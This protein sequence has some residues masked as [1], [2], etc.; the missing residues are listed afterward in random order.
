M[1][2][3]GDGKGQ[4]VLAHAAALARRH[5]AHVTV[6]HCRARAGDMM[7]YGVPVPALVRRQIE[8]SAASLADEEERALRTEF[9]ELLPRFGLTEREAAP[10]EGPSA[11]WREAE[12]RQIDVIRTHGRLADIVCVA[13]PDRDRN[14]GANTLKAALF[15]T[16]RPVM[17][18]PPSDPSD[19]LG[20]HVAIGWNGSL[21]AARAT[22]LGRPLLTG[23]DR[24]TVLTAGEEPHGATAEGLVAKLG[25]LGVA[26]ELVRFEPTGGIGRS[27]LEQ[28]A[29]AGADTLLMGAYHDSREQETVF[30]GNT[31]TVVDTA[32][33][34][35]VLVH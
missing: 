12:G 4:G 1:P 33:M 11:S 25:L 26:A 22:G 9:A 5:G 3:R 13:K 34:P 19:T 2:V 18:C 7:P 32:M 21:E 30:G 27:L 15:A 31:Q 6:L 17:M 14:L 8:E 24:V 23:A 28:A 29:A 10:G 20:S 16:G 35:V